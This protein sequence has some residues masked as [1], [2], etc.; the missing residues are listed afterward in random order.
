MHI[1]YPLLDVSIRLTPLLGFGFGFNA[2]SKVYIHLR[3][4]LV[5]AL[6]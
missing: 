4:E 1:F 5:V 3:C 2:C 6:L